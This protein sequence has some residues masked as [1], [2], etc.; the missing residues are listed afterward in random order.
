MYKL[1][2]LVLTETSFMQDV[3]PDTIIKDLAPPGYSVVNESRTKGAKKQGGEIAI[4]E[5]DGIRMSRL[6]VKI[7]PNCFFCQ[8][9]I[10]VSK[11]QHR[12]DLQTI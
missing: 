2:V 8:S 10:R 3:M 5:C 9:V 7:K 11:I 6:K 1:D 4:I 12:W